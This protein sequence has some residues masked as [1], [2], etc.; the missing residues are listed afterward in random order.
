MRGYEIKWPA[1]TKMFLIN[2]KFDHNFSQFEPV[3][4]IITKIFEML[5]VEMC[6]MWVSFCQ[7]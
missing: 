7:L 4:S 1:I 5:E 6:V 2:T 3:N